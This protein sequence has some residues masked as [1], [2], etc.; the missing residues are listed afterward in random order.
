MT[1]SRHLGIFCLPTL[2]LLQV[3]NHQNGELQHGFLNSLFLF[4]AGVGGILW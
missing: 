3:E 1:S 2:I 4:G